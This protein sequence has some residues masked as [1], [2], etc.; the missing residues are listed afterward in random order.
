M[1]VADIFVW[2]KVAPPLIRIH[3]IEKT[4]GSQGENAGYFEVKNKKINLISSP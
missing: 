2:P 1:A 3:P 4:G